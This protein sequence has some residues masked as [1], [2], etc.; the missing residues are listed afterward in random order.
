M[1]PVGIFGKTEG[2]RAQ[3]AFRLEQPGRMEDSTLLSWGRTAR[4]GIP[5]RHI[6][7]IEKS[8]ED[9]HER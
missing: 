1:E 2:N 8:Q 5:R 4:F 6:D 3:Q 9:E 7:F